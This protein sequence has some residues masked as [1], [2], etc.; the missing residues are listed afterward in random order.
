[1]DCTEQ[2]TYKGMDPNVV[3]QDGPLA[4]G[5]SLHMCRPAVTLLE[6]SRMRSGQK[7]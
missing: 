1:M 6:V 4:L 2:Q 3:D 7:V 5:S